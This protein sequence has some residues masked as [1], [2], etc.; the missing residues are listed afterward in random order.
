MKICYFGIY[1]PNYSRNRILNGGLR[2]NGVEV[3][4]CRTELKGVKKYFDLVKKHWRIR[5]DYDAMVVGFPGYQA[6][7]LARFLTRKII[8]FDAFASAYDSSV[9]DRKLVKPKSLKALYYWTLDWLPC[10]L[11]D[12]VLL[13]TNEHIKY[14][15]E[16]FRIKPEKFFRI[17]IG[18]DDKIY[19]PE[20]ENPNKK[21]TVLF[22]GTFIPLQG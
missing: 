13:D 15:V 6:M 1:D 9:F 16:T 5:K 17:F 20:I 14:F 21:F 8:I 10:R 3:I 18:A 22:F 11:A 12:A 4:E 7:I 19:Y 2:E